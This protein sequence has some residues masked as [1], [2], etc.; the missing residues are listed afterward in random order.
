MEGPN[1][2]VFTFLGVESFRKTDVTTIK[3]SIGS[4][5]YLENKSMG[6]ILRAEQIATTR[7]LASRERPN[8]TI[9]FPRADAYYL[10]QFFMLYEIAT[11]FAGA[12]YDINPFDQPGVELGKK[13]TKEI[14]SK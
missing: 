13:L 3:N 5:G 9:T 12:L 2:K 14:L 4:F 8:L 7:A 6:E 10:G 1:D 11:A